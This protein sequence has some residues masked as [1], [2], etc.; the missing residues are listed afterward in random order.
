VDELHA[1][2]E[3]IVACNPKLARQLADQALASGMAADLIVASALVPAMTAVGE[4]FECGEFFVPELLLAARAMK[5]AFEPL[6]PLLA[7]TS[8]RRVGRVVIGTVKGD[9]HD[10]GKNVVAAMLK[11]VGFDVVDLGADVAPAAF[12]DAVR[13]HE[14]DIVALSAL[15]STTLSSMKATITSLEE[16]GLRDKVRVM[17]GGAPVSGDYARAIGADGYG[18]SAVAAVSLAR[19]LAAD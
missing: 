8:V 15:L 16:A 17:V 14:A 12:V 5:A 9:L 2:K 18:D 19:R 13:R 6:E 3:A 1:L 10:I 4:R 11:G 7:A